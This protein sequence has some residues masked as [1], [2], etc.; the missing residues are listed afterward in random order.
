MLNGDLHRGRGSR[1]FNH[2]SISEPLTTTSG[3]ITTQ[4]IQSPSQIKIADSYSCTLPVPRKM[5]AETRLATVGEYSA[6]VLICI[7]F[8]VRPSSFSQYILRQYR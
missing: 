5:S 1:D 3:L 2:L 8:L 7:P 4:P 6:V